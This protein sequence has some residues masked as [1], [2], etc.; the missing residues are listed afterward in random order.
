M[1]ESTTFLTPMDDWSDRW[2]NINKYLERSGPFTDPG[3]K[4][5]EQ[6]HT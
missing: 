4:P 5:G 3:F 1:D 2:N 6:V